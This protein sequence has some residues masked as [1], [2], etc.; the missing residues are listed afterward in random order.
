[1]SL[2]YKKEFDEPREGLIRQELIT[3]EK[4]DGMFFKTITVRNFHKDGDYTDTR[5]VIP[6]S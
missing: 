6:L 2:P 1:M 4:I 3:Y 5:T